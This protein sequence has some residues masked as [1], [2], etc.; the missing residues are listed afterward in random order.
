M[1]YL[2]M[3]PIF[4]ASL[5]DINSCIPV[6]SSKA[7]KKT[8]SFS[9]QQSATAIFRYYQRGDI[10]ISLVLAFERPS[11]SCLLLCA[12]PKNQTKHRF[13]VTAA[14]STVGYNAVSGIAV[15]DSAYP[16]V[17]A[18]KRMTPL[19]FLDSVIVAML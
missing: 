3:M 11:R 13:P 2:S 18:R 14:S 1:S 8:G 5:S 17:S 6:A 7:V 12:W 16:H 15:M 4:H 19:H 10:S 9:L